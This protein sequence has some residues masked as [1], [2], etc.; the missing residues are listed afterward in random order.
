V[1]YQDRARD[2]QLRG[3]LAYKRKIADIYVDML[4]VWLPQGPHINFD[5][6]CGQKRIR[7]PHRRAAKRN[8]GKP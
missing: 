3:P 4:D 6:H 8:K 1:Y 5:K 2:E 7:G